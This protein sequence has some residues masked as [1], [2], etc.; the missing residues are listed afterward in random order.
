MDRHTVGH[1]HEHCHARP[2]VVLPCKGVGT[3]LVLAQFGT[4]ASNE[5]L[6]HGVVIMIVSLDNYPLPWRYK[7]IGPLT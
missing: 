7:H 4:F 5:Y 2:R 3:N 1:G 6:H